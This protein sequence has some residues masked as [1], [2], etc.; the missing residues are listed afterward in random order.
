[1]TDSNSVVLDSSAT[2]DIQLGGTTQ[3]TGYDEYTVGGRL[4]LI[5][6]TLNITL[7][8]GF[9]PAAGES[10]EI[11]EWGSLTGTFG[12][13]TIP[14]LSAGLGWD[15]SALYTIGT[16]TVENTSAGSSDG[17]LPLWALGA[18]GAG[19]VSIGSRR[20]K[21]T[22]HREGPARLPTVATVFKG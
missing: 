7:T 6:P 2:L 4:T 9:V 12:T 22:A 1:V 8:N 13:V 18:L 19:L 16:I 15:M 17:P 11:L 5:Q 10:F 3:C 21:K 14:S 20:L